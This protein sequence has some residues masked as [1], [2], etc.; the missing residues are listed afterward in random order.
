MKPVKLD[1][2]SLDILKKLVGELDA[3][4]DNS[5]KI[6][7]TADSE[8]S[9]YIVEMAKA[10]GL[11]AGIMQES[12]YL[13]NDI[14]VLVKNIQQPTPKNADILDKLMAGFKGTGGSTN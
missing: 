6:R 4:L 2:V 13:I 5:E 9:D 7:A 8:M 14:Q 10:A 12:G 1:R 3:S 11:A